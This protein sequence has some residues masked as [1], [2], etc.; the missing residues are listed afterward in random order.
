M[1]NQ[2]ESTH[3]E[4]ELSPESNFSIDDD[5]ED[6]EDEL[7]ESNAQESDDEDPEET[8]A[9]L[10]VFEDEADQEQTQEEATDEQKGKLSE[11]LKLRE[12]IP[13]DIKESILN[14]A[15]GLDKIQDRRE[16]EWGEKEGLYTAYTQLGQVL[17][18]PTTYQEGLGRMVVAYATAHG[19]SPDEVLEA[20]ADNLD[21]YQRSMGKPAPITQASRGQSPEVV[22]LRQRLAQLEQKLEEKNAKEQTKAKESTRDEKLKQ[23]LEVNAPRIISSAKKQLS[24]EVTPEQVATAIKAHPGK[25]PLTALKKEFPDEYRAAGIP[26]RST[27]PTMTQSATRRDG[28]RPRDPADLTAHDILRMARSQG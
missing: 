20:L 27:V 17:D 24:W 12:G 26:K 14:H 16:R 5:E 13:D 8:P 7:E 22:E 25:D 4:E 23:F 21:T 11:T 19:A 15:K 9:E 2:E 3:E 28:T 1:P 6:D 18:D 10:P